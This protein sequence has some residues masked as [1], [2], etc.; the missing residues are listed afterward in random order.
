MKSNQ[1]KLIMVGTV[2]QADHTSLR[3]EMHKVYSGL[4]VENL[5]LK[6]KIVELEHALAKSARPNE[7]RVV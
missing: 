3:K 7:K 5:D 6:S 4:N 1:K 2:T